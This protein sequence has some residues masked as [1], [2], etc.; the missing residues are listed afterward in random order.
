MCVS[1]IASAATFALGGLL[2][3]LMATWR[4]GR[5]ILTRRLTADLLPAA[6]FV[7]DVQRR[8]PTRVPGTAVFLYSNPEATP[9]ALLHN[10]KHNRVLHERILFVSVTVVDEPQVRPGDRASV[11]SLGDGFF[12]VILRYGFMEE[13]DIPEALSGLGPAG[14]V[15]RPMETTYFLGRETV[16]RSRSGR[17]SRWRAALFGLMNRNATPASSFFRLPPNRV[18]ELGAQIEL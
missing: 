17:I 18:V 2:L 5:A 3:L 11:E 16:V 4:R 7:A 13:P 15:L 1:H 8:A 6:A 12:R 9:P 14:L 10:L